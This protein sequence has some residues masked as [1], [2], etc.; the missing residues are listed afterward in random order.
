V[1]EKRQEKTEIREYFYV[2]G[3][4]RSFQQKYLVKS[5]TTTIA[6]LK[7]SGQFFGQG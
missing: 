1:G 7:I 2:C 5:T 4:L 6:F 3:T